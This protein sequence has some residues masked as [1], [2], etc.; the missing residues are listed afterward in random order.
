MM[1]PLIILSVTFLAVL[2]VFSSVALHLEAFVRNDFQLNPAQTAFPAILMPVSAAFRG[3]GGISIGLIIAAGVAAG[4]Y[5]SLF[6]R[7]VVERWR[8]ISQDQY[9]KLF[10][11]R[12]RNHKTQ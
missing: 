4:I 12:G 7:F 8:W 6:R 9:Q 10:P 2:L 5:Q 3:R 11:K 1:K